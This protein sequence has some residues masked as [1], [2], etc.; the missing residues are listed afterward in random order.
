MYKIEGMLQGARKSLWMEE[1]GTNKQLNAS[2]SVMLTDELKDAVRGDVI[3]CVTDANDYIVGYEY[4]YSRGGENKVL[5]KPISSADFT[6]NKVTSLVMHNGY[7][8]SREGAL[9]KCNNLAY[10]NVKDVKDI[11][12]NA[13]TLYTTVIPSAVTV[14]VVDD[15]EEKIFA[16]SSDDILDYERFDNN[17]SMI[18]TRFRSDL[19]KEIIIYNK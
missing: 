3:R 9:I 14:V 7:V 17:C 1:D 13:E 4:I 18:L 5:T 12:M 19:L 6:P 16:G 11:D 15:T 8:Y 10:G 2:G